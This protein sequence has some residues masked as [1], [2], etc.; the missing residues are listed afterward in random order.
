MISRNLYFQL[1][2]RVVL[3]VIIALAAGFCG[4]TKGSST[5]VVLL[6]VIE[7]LVVSEPDQIFEYYQ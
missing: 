6:L 5:L 1:V 2:F 4:A 3:I 7:T